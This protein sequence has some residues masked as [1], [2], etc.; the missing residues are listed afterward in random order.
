MKFDNLES[1]IEYL[2]ILQGYI[3]KENMDIH[4]IEA[5]KSAIQLMYEY[6]DLGYKE[7]AVTRESVLQTIKDNPDNIEYA[8]NHLPRMKARTGEWLLTNK[9]IN[10]ITDSM[11]YE[12]VCSECNKPAPYN[13]EDDG[14]TSNPMSPMSIYLYL[15]DYCPFCGTSMIKTSTS[16]KLA[17]IY[18]INI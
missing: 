4:Y 5:L 17:S 18:K 3:E 13:Y 15:S 7:D 9:Y 12:Y 10:T 8:I 6:S 14:K 2:N 1:Q 16:P 11:E